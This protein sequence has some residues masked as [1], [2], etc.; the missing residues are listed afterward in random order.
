MKQPLTRSA[1]SLALGAG[2]AVS[3]LAAQ[4]AF[5]RIQVD[6]N[7]TPV[8]FQGVQP[9]SLHGR[10]FIPLRA[11]AESLDARVQ[12]DPV[13]QSVLGSR[14]SRRFTLPI[15]SRT[16]SVQ[17]RSVYLDEPARLMAGTTMVPL[18]FAAEAL[19]AEVDWN[20]AAQRVA[21]NLAGSRSAVS[22]YRED[23]RVDSRDEE[24]EERG[25]TVIPADTVVRVRLEENLNSRTVEN[26]ERFTVSVAEDDRSRFPRGTRLE[27]RITDVQRAT[28]DHPGVIDMAFDRALLPDGASVPISG[29][30]ASLDRDDVRRTSDGRLETRNRKSAKFQPKWVGYGAAGGAVLSTI[31]GGGFLKGALIGAAGGAVYGY[32]DQKKQN[33]RNNV[34]EVDLRAGTEF[35]VRLNERLAL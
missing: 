18:R 29:S 9:Q 6:V 3:L 13:T 20:A 22:G 33:K 23:D 19:G 24:R 26:G 2:A 11:V 1:V 28:K 27:G 10:V 8:R 12:W 5:A 32:L 17:G 4:P 35:G 34:D 7:G 16:A 25:R 14:G 30:L 15:G 21:I 31:L